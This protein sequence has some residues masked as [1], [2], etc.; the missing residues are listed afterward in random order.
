M[1]L[2]SFGKP[3]PPKANNKVW[4]TREECLKGTVREC[5]LSIRNSEIA[6]IAFPFEESRQA[7][8]TFLNK[9]PVPFQ[10]IDTYAG[11]DILSTTDKIFLIDLFP[12]T[13]LSSDRKINFFILG[14]YPYLPE[15]RKSLEHLRIKFPNAVISFC[16]SL[17]D[18]V[19]KVFGSERLKPLMESLGMK[20][21][22]FI[23]HAMINTSIANG[24]E[25]IEQKV[26]N[27]LKSSSEKGWFERNLIEL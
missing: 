14:R 6:I 16:L 26:V 17:D 18:T 9:A 22:E 25:K 8:E 15:E 23:E 5:L 11:K 20:E 21:D 4:K 3:S 2:F 7:M 10:S 12:L 1:G 13:N 24:L 27:E 19:F